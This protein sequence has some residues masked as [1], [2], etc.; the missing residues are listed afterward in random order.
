MVMDM[1]EFFLTA[2][3]HKSRVHATFKPESKCFLKTRVSFS[4]LFRA[5]E[6]TLWLTVVG[7]ASNLSIVIQPV[8]LDP[9]SSVV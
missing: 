2:S 7:L 3:I 4:R 6:S 5:R 8:L 1:Y 9:M